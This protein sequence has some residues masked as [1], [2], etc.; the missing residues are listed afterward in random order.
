MYSLFFKK[1][2]PSNKLKKEAERVANE[3]L[4]VVPQQADVQISVQRT[5][6]PSRSFQVSML[7]RGLSRPIVMTRVGHGVYNLLRQVEKQ[8]LREIKRLKEK[9]MDA[10]RVPATWTEGGPLPS[11]AYASSDVS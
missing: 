11:R 8:T 9:R 10:T 2:R 6:D 1:V 4:E 7:V 5:Q 3:I